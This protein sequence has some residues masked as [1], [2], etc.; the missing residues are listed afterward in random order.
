MFIIAIIS[1]SILCVLL[2]KAN[3]LIFH[4]LSSPSVDAMEGAVASYYHGWVGILAD[5]G[6][7]KRELGSPVDAIGGLSHPERVAER[8]VAV[9]FSLLFP[10]HATER[11]VDYGEG[12]VREGDGIYAGIIV[13]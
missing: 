7:L 8:L 12:S 1:C 5:G 10:I 13:G 6:G 11:I 9:G 4:S 3:P 2:L